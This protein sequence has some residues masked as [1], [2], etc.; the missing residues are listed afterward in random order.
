MFSISLE[1]LI[2]LSNSNQAEFEILSL[3]ISY[4]VEV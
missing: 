2:D 3:F 1:I 4:S